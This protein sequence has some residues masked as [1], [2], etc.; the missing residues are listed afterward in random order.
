MKNQACYLVL[1][2]FFIGPFYKEAEAARK[3]VI[4]PQKASISVKVADR[5]IYTFSHR[6]IFDESEKLISSNY[7][8]VLILT[9][10]Q[11]I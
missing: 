7:L 9:Y 3:E 8:K 1:I 4:C 2:L 6:G 5:R 11:I 10:I